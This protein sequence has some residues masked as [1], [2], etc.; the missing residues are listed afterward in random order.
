MQTTGRFGVRDVSSSRGLSLRLRASGGTV[1]LLLA[2]V[3]LPAGQAETAPAAV[4]GRVFLDA[5]TNGILDAGEKGLP[6][7][8]V[9]DGMQIVRTGP[10][11]KYAITI[12]ADPSIPYKPYQV[13]TVCWPS[14]T[15][16][17]GRWWRRLGT[18]EDPK[19]VNFGLR[20]DTQPLP[21]AFLHMS[22]NHDN[23]AVYPRVAADVKRMMP[24]ARFIINTGDLGYASVGNAEKMF[25][26]VATNAKS[27][28]VPILHIPGNHDISPG[29]QGVGDG[30]H[31]LAHYGGYVKHLGPV[32]WSFDYAG[33]HFVGVDWRGPY[34]RF[35]Q[36]DRK[37]V[38]PGTMIFAFVHYRSDMGRVTHM[39]YGHTHTQARHGNATGVVNPSGD[40]GW[41]VGVVYNGGKS[42]ERVE[43][44]AG[45]KKGQ[46]GY[47]SRRRCQIRQLTYTWMAGIAARRL[48]ARVADKRQLTNGVHTIQAA[49]GRGHEIDV[50][51]S[52]GEA[53]RCG[54]R[55]GARQTVEIAVEGRLIHV[56]GIPIPYKPRE[57]IKTVSLH[58]VV[59]GDRL[60]LYIDKLMHVA[61]G[62]KID[63][64]S[65]ITLFAEGGKATF[66]KA[67]VWPLKQMKGKGISN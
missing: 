13:L 33:C 51:F 67:T 1:L 29:K 20:E 56:D 10:E 15:W 14:Y 55:I 50:A 31:P 27:V 45:C 66:A 19:N 2:A 16:P 9:S 49:A 60:I 17:S 57:E 46:P 65:R 62:V 63:D 12:A 32:R 53:K 47:H 18:I 34:G 37:G 64:T 44:C 59:E 52:P 61:R 3:S 54:I 23:G 48:K 6:D 24:M 4:G 21:F 40:G 7:I 28:P 41:N 5:N 42:F 35:L 8:G 43:R 30:E 22:D 58:A 36:A 25:S 38:K 26:S 39:F 11:G